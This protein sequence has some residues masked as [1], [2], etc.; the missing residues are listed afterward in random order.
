MEL[1]ETAMEGG[2]GGGGFDEGECSSR[3]RDPE[4]AVHRRGSIVDGVSRWVRNY[5]P[6]GNIQTFCKS[7]FPPLSAM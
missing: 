2:G 4:V 6:L 1:D 5:Q 7:I 3:S